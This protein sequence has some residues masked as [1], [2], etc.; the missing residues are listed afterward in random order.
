M[1]RPQ[2]SPSECRVTF[3]DVWRLRVVMALGTGLAMYGWSMASP[4]F[5]RDRP[6]EPVWVAFVVVGVGVSAVATWCEWRVRR[7]GRRGRRSPR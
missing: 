5:V 6:I 3:R 7:G 2:L 1:N 4:A